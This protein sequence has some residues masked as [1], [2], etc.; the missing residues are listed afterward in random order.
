MTNK[1]VILDNSVELYEHYIDDDKWE[2]TL[3][4]PRGGVTYLVSN[5]TIK[6]YAYEDYLYRNCII[7][8]QLPIHVVDEF[9]HID[10][11]Y[12]DID[13]LVEV[14]DRIFPTNDIDAELAEYLR[15]KDAELIYQPKGD[16][17]L[18]SEVPDLNSF[19]TDEELVDALDDYYTKD[20]TSGKT[21]IQDALDGKAD[22]SDTYTKAEVDN[23]TNGKADANDVYTKRECDSKF[24]LN[25][26]YV[27][28]NTFISYT[29][30]TNAALANK[31]NRDELP[32]ITPY[33]DDAEYDTARKEIVFYNKGVEKDSIDARPFIKDGMVSDVKIVGDNLVITFNTDS[34]KEPISIPLSSIF[35]PSNYYTKNESDGRF[36]PKGDYVAENE[37]DVFTAT[38]SADIED[39][40]ND[41]LDVTAYTPTDLSNYYTKQEVYNKNETYNRNEIDDK[42]AEAGGFDP[43]KYY[44]KTVSDNRFAFKSD[45]PSLDGY[46][47]EDWV[48]SKKYATA[49][50]VQQYITNLQQQINSIVEAVSGC[51]QT[52][53]TIYRW[54]TLTGPNDYLCSGTTKY[55]KQVY[56]QSTDGGMTWTNVQPIE[57]RRGAVLETDSSDCGYVPDPQ[58]RWKAAPASDY[59][60]SGTSKYYKEYY[61]VSYDE[62]VTWEHVVPEQTRRGSLIE[63]QSTD[64]G[65]IP[66]QYRWYTSQSEYICSGTTKYEKQYY[67][68]SYDNGSSWQNVS[69]LQTRTGSVIEYNS[70]DCGYEPSN[71]S[72]YLTFIPSESGTFKFTKNGNGND[73]QYSLD[74]GS[75]W[76]TLASN[77][78]TPTI[79][80]GNKIM[81]KGEITPSNIVGSDGV[82]IFSSSGNFVVEGNPMSLIYGDNFVDKKSLSGKTYAF[83]GLFS[84]CNKLLSAENL[85]LIA[86]TLD[87]HCYEYM[88]NNCTSLTTA[89]ELPA[90]TLK[91][92]CYAGMFNN[93]T[94]L[95]NAPA[96]PSTKLAAMCYG[97]MFKGCTSLT[98]VP[99]LPATTMRNQCYG[100]M[101]SGCTSL[102]TAPQLIATTLEIDCY[103]HMF[104]GCTSLATVPSNMLP[105]TRLVVGCY[106]SMFCGCTS[107]TTAPQLPVPTNQVIPDSSYMD[108]FAGCTSLTTAPELLTPTVRLGAYQGMFANCTSLNYIKCLTTNFSEYGSTFRWVA[109]VAANG[110]FVK[111]ANMTKWT[112]G[113]DGIPSGWTVQDA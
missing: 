103:M 7:S 95:T 43:T 70:V 83:Y 30:T 22:K 113:D 80:S 10:G 109:N 24:Q 112:S 82:G 106:E 75:T 53:E 8:M 73:I 37:Y 27:S 57:Y 12:E 91:Y 36:Q 3:A 108:M 59:M 46:A 41:K 32:D 9:E 105:A 19:V 40:K 47:T 26:N 100:Y 97:S 81:W 29:A 71:A 63:A 14:L 4:F 79:T 76:T 88:F 11:E 84:G 23:L 50:S 17:I 5:G 1:I 58:Y 98:A 61:E 44:T 54:L 34:G 38:T 35:N 93:C 86:T 31:A 78:N 72:K 74:S 25:G 77:T 69:P 64:C 49:S 13:E 60:C 94:S 20:E 67:Q 99:Q 56:Q 18:R 55:E 87:G 65:Y 92:N 104:E 21:E 89:P 6:F 85:A 90:M 96:L 111:A 39:L 15:I 33:F 52:V 16:Y 102:T 45:I 101:F 42:I 62:G 2:K 110:T 107:L 48:L 68:V 28:A 66:P 51:C